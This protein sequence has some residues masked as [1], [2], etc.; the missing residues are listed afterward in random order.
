MLRSCISGAE[1]RK[2]LHIARWN[3]NQLGNRS[4]YDHIPLREQTREGIKAQVRQQEKTISTQIQVLIIE[5]PSGN[6]S[7]KGV[8]FIDGF[9]KFVC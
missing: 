8:D 3:R 4:S 6:I 5:L 1:I 7:R 2:V 9:S